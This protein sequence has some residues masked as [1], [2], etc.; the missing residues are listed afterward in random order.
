MVAKFLL[1]GFSLSMLS[2]LEMY[3]TSGVFA[4]LFFHSPVYVPL[5]RYLSIYLT[6]MVFG[7]FF[8]GIMIGLQNFRSEARWRIG[9]ILNSYSA[10]LLLLFLFNNSISIVIGWIAGSAFSVVSSR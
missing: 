9:S 6:F 2:L 10:A 3:F 7:S 5:L 4:M 8:W 1:I